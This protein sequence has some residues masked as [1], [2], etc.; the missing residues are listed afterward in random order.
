MPSDQQTRPTSNA[1]GRPDK[2]RPIY[3][4]YIR[5]EVPVE[6]ETHCRGA[7]SV[8]DFAPIQSKVVPTIC[9]IANNPQAQARR[10]TVQSG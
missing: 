2:G 10:N 8:K 4:F 9:E 7:G 1:N 3:C 5:S 6:P